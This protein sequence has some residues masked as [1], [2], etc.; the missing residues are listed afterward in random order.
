MSD[1][2]AP[3]L[4]P[5]SDAEL[6]ARLGPD[7][8]PACVAD[9]LER[10]GGLP[11]LFR[12]A[13]AG[14]LPQAA[15]PLGPVLNAV[16]EL[17]RRRALASLRAGPALTRPGQAADYLA[18]TLSDRSRE[19]FGCLYLDT[20]HRVLGWEVLFEGSL[21]GAQV[22]P[23]VVAERALRR[24]ASALIVAHNHPSGVA[25]PSEADRLITERLR[26]ALALLDIRLLD[27]FIVGDGAPVSMAARGLI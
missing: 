15:A 1:V 5:D 13:R 4:Q 18:A 26:A 7:A 21:D 27:H 25:E 11:G 3:A 24:A 17:N 2:P 12:A 22:H 16:R 14:T 6:L 9:L 8:D 19:A 10:L 23:R 20:R